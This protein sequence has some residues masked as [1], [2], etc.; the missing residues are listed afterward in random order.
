MF[1]DVFSKVLN[2]AFPKSRDLGTFDRAVSWLRDSS[3]FAEDLD[4]SSDQLANGLGSWLEFLYGFDDLS[5][6]EMH[7]LCFYASVLFFKYAGI[8]YDFTFG[9]FEE[10][11]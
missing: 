2:K 5:E 10:V 8:I 7:C 6:F 4:V 9:S 1:D 11:K 3:L